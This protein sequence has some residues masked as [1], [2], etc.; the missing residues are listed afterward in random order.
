MNEKEIES[1]ANKIILKMMKIKT[2][3]DWMYDTQYS[4]RALEKDHKDLQMSEEE[5]AI[6]EIA[7]LM[8]LKNLF[9]D[10]E[11]YEKCAIVKKRIQIVNNILKN[12]K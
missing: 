10:K 7:K 9:E 3:E 6:G 2:M 5:S 1:L 4:E 8:T 12:Y 11:E